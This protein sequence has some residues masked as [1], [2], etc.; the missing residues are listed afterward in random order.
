M[1]FELVIY[2]LPT[3]GNRIFENVRA[4]VTP[5]TRTLNLFIRYYHLHLSINFRSGLFGFLET[6]SVDIC[7]LIYYRVVQ[8]I[9]LHAECSS[10]KSIYSKIFIHINLFLTIPNT[11]KKE[12]QHNR[13]SHSHDLSYM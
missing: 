10:F 6:F 3:D 5:K 8:M 2:I 4:V 11:K 7:K 9:F 12:N 1:I 13:S